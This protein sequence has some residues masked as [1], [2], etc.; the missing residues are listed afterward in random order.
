MQDAYLPSTVKK[1]SYNWTD[2]NP[3]QGIEKKVTVHAEKS[4]FVYGYC[5]N[6]L[7]MK[8]VDTT[9]VKPS[10]ISSLKVSKIKQDSMKL[11][12]SKASKATGYYV[13]Q[14]NGDSW[15]KIATVSKTNYTVKNL[16]PNKNYKFKVVAYR[17]NDKTT[18]VSKETTITQKTKAMEKPD[19]VTKLKASKIGENFI[20]LTWNKSQNATGYNVYQ[21][22]DTTKKWVKLDTV[23]KKSYRVT[24]LT[25]KSKYKFKVVAENKQSYG[26]KTGEAVT[27]SAKT[28]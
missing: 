2:S 24:G 7:G 12:W 10:K 13:Y 11:T 28:K 21:Y 4:S 27:I 14:K 16:K 15:D 23:T 9:P 8:V 18:T 3:F 17:N 5:K 6:I 25:E 22:D 1:M 26:T 20:N 19:K